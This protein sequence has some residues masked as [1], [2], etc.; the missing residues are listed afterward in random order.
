MLCAGAAVQGRTRGLNFFVWNF[1]WDRLA[2]R[3]NAATATPFRT[4]RYQLIIRYYHPLLEDSYRLGGEYHCLS[5]QGPGHNPWTR[6]LSRPQV[7]RPGYE[8][9]RASGRRLPWQHVCIIDMQFSF[10][11]AQGTTHAIFIVCQLHGNINANVNHIMYIALV[12]LK[13]ALDYVPRHV[14]SWALR[15]KDWLLHLI[16]SIYKIAR[17]WV[18]LGCNLSEA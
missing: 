8:G 10:I 14:I 1:A 5:L 11:P 7:A 3:L 16:Q 6:K 2:S 17:S 18:C 9:V 12:N 4:W 13:K 15:I